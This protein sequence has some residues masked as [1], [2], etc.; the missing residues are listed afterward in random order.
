[1]KEAT[2]TAGIENQESHHLKIL[3]KYDGSILGM[4]TTDG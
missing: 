2:G 3:K 4:P 1:M